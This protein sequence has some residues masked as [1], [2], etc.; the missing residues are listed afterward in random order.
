MALHDMPAMINYVLTTTDHLTLSYAG[1]SE[2]TMEVFASFSVD[3]ELV[4]KVSYFGTL[5]PV[6]YPGRI[7]SPIFDLM[8]D[9]YLVLGIGAL[10]ETYWLIQD[11]MAKYACAFVDQAFGSIVNALT[12][13]SE[14][15]NSTRLAVH[16]TRCK[17]G[18]LRLSVKPLKHAVHHALQFYIFSHKLLVSNQKPLKSSSK[19]T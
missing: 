19:V 8:T 9:T 2:E 14:N 5:A 13:Q 12:R 10:W 18:A 17:S 1:H 7:T 4:K 11:I 3:Q 6:A 16:A 15:V